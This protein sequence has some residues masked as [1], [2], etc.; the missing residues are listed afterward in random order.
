MIR[1]ARIN[2]YDEPVMVFLSIKITPDWEFKKVVYVSAVTFNYNYN[3][4]H[5]EETVMTYVFYLQIK[6]NN[7]K[8]NNKKREG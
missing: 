6:L 8:V 1:I 5:F 2:K 7:F 4:N 3:R